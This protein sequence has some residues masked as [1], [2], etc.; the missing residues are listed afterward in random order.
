MKAL[1]FL[2]LLP[3]GGDALLDENPPDDENSVS[4]TNPWKSSYDRCE[5]QRLGCESKLEL[6]DSIPVAKGT[7]YLLKYV[8]NDF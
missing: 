5:L 8:F 7:A 6:C 2:C 4:T 1:I 3:W